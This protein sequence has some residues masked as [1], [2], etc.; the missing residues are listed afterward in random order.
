VLIQIGSEDTLGGAKSVE[1][2]ARSYLRRS[3]LTQVRVIVYP[4]ARHEVFNETNR[5]EVV[6]DTIG[7]LKSQF[8]PA[9]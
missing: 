5:D 1:L 7:W 9:L 3:R 2:L 8:A 4:E 6:S